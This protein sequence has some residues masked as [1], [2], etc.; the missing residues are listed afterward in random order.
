MDVGCWAMVTSIDVELI[1][2]IIRRIAAYGVLEEGRM[3]GRDLATI[4]VAKPARCQTLAQAIRLT[5]VFGPNLEDGP[6]RGRVIDYLSWGR[7]I[8]L[9][10]RERSPCLD[11]QF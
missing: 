5:A 1:E 4:P 8:T 10:G 2:E 7:I 3:E 9:L 11:T 6:L